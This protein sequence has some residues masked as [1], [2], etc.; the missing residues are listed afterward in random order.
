MAFRTFRIKNY[1]VFLGSKLSIHSVG[2]PQDVSAR[3]LIHCIGEEGESLAIF[4]L[5]GSNNWSNY[6]E[7]SS[8]RVRGEIFAPAEQY[9]W[10]ID[11]LRNED[12][13]F[14]TIDD[15]KPQLN[16]IWCNEPVGDGEYIQF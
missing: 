16:R 6:S 13:V 4:F 3:A 11:I 14:G 2:N 9:S 1:W 12:P 7:I 15:S 8:N 10:Y 5:D